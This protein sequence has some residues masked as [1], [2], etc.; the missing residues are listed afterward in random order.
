MITTSELTLETNDPNRSPFLSPPFASGSRWC[1][2]GL[3]GAE[4]G[5]AGMATP[6]VR[7][8]LGKPGAPC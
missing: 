1:R 8:L 5:D 2:G 7:W 6:C 4:G 3:R